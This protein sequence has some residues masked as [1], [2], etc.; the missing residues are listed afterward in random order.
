MGTGTMRTCR[1]SRRSEGGFTL[2]EVLAALLIAAV[3]LTCAVQ[4]ETASLQISH[5]SRQ[6]REA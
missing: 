2:L 1:K 3:A 6:R 4:S 5:R